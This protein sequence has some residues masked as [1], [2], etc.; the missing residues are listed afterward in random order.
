VIYM[1]LDCVSS[2][3]NVSVIK[4]VKLVY[5]MTILKFDKSLGNY[6]ILTLNL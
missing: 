4:Y 6:D 5:P 2:S 1:C 3:S